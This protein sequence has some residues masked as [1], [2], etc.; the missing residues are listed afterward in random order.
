MTEFEKKV[1]KRRKKI[2]QL[3]YS[4]LVNP[5]RHSPHTLYLLLERWISGPETSGPALGSH[6]VILLFT[7]IETKNL[8]CN[9]FFEATDMYSVQ[10]TMIHKLSKLGYSIACV[11]R[12]LFSC[13]WSVLASVIN[14][15]SLYLISH[16]Y[17]IVTLCP[18][19]ITT[20]A[21]G[22]TA[23]SSGSW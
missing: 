18:L 16:G 7:Q 3:D 12:M 10:C 4:L 20:S 11:G 2:W 23:H 15:C 1:R 14:I 6:S 5:R 8:N 21:F 22:Y 19:L 13:C 17:F 9:R